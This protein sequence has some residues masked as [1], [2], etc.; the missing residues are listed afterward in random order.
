MICLFNTAFAK[1]ETRM[2]VLTNWGLSLVNIDKAWDITQGSSDI[3]VAVIDTGVDTIH[4]SLKENL[5]VNPGETGVD[6]KGHDKSTNGIDDDGNGF[7]DDVHG[8]NF[9]NNSNDLTDRHG[10]GT[11]VAGIIHSSA[12]KTNL[13]ILKYFD[14]KA[15]GESNLANTVKAIQYAIKMKAR[16]INYSGGGTTQYTDE[17][18]AVRKAQEAGILFVAAAGNEYSNSDISGFYPADYGFSNIASVTAIDENQKVLNSSNY[19]IR[20]VDIAAPGRNINSTLPGGKFGPMTGTSQATAFV[21]GAAALLMAENPELIREPEKVISILTKTGFTNE[22]L[23]GK[24]KSETRLDTYRSLIMKDQ[25]ESAFG[26]ISSQVFSLTSTDFASKLNPEN[27]D[28]GV[29]ELPFKQISSEIL[30]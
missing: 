13:M 8:W 3:V 22:T 16:I 10:H 28:F 30:H 15:T 7:I 29:A 18:N 14:P 12:P 24:T 21:T 5:W 25:D 4:P 20:T 27:E 23:K 11:H 26:N 6:D 19:G 17:E 1:A 2:E 9:A